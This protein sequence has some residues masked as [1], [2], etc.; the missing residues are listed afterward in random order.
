MVLPKHKGAFTNYV[1][2]TK[3]VRGTGNDIGIQ[4]FPY[5]SK[6]NSF[7]NVNPV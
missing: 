5:N 7:T 4:I 3:Y 1:D 6:N 2:K